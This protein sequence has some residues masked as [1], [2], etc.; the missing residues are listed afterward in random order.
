MKEGEGKGSTV[1]YRV[2]IVGA[3]LVVA[4]SLI[5]ILNPEVFQRNQQDTLKVGILH[6]LTGT[7]AISES[8][9]VDATLM[10]IEEINEQGGVLGKKLNPS[11]S[12]EDRMLSFSQSKPKDSSLK[13]KSPSSS[14]AGHPHAERPLNRSSKG[15]T[16][17]SSIQC[18]MKASNNPRTSSTPETSPSISQ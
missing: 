4:L 15:S 3:A 10:A 7:L 9:V 2:L 17:F 14:D 5:F 13:K 8:S 6:S 16:I 18:N 11:S 1:Q 12:T